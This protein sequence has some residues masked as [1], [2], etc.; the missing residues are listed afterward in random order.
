MIWTSHSNFRD[1]LSM[2]NYVV[3]CVRACVLCV[4]ARVQL[5]S[6]CCSA[7]VLCMSSPT[8][9]LSNECRHTIQ[10]RLLSKSLMQLL[11]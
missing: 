4:W 6:C 3:A 9:S 8:Q 7:S 5:H 1:F 10:A 11:P 2:H